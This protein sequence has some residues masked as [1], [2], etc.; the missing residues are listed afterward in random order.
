MSTEQQQQKHQPPDTGPAYYV[1]IGASA[2]GLEALET[3]FAQMPSSTGLAFIVIQHLS[4]DYKSL[5]VEL[6]SKKTDMHVHRAE[7]GMPIEPNCVYLIPPRKTLTMYRGR[8]LLRDQAPTRGLNLPIDV[9]FRSLADDQGERAVAIVLSGTGSDGTRGIR[10]VKD[11]GGLVFVQ[12]PKSARFDGMPRAA[13][14]TGL[15]D[16]VLSPEAMPDQLVRI[17]DHPHE[18]IRANDEKRISEDEG[19]L[20]RIFSL[21]RERVGADFSHYKSSTVLRRIERR[22]MVAQ[23]TDLDD[24]VGFMERRSSEVVKLYKELLIHVTSFFRDREVFEYL[25]SD[26]LPRMLREN[27]KREFRLWV[28]G[29][30]TGEEA[31]TLAILCKETAHNLG[32][33]ADIKLFATDIDRDAIMPA[34]IGSYPESTVADVPG[35]YLAKYFH[36]DESGFR[37]ARTIREMVVFA[38]HNVLS[39]PPFTNLDLISCRNLLI[40]LQ[41]SMQQKALELFNFALR[42]RGI[43]LLGTSETVGDLGEYY[44]CVH[45]KHRVYRS[46][47]RRK[48]PA[49]RS[50]NELPVAVRS[51]PQVQRSQHESSSLSS[52]DAVLERFLNTVVGDYLPLTVIVNESLEI[53]HI[54]GDTK[55]YFRLP[56]GRIVNDISR[57]ATK[58]LSIPLS[59]G[60]RKAFETSSQIRYSGIRLSDDP[61]GTTVTMR[62]KPLDGRKNQELLAAVFL[63][64]S[65]TEANSQKD[66]PVI[67]YNAAEETQQR[68]RDLEHEL[69]FTKENL[70]ATIE[71]L[72]TSNEELQATN[73][74]LLASNEELQSTNEELQSVNEELHTVNAEYQGKLIEY[75]ELTHDLEN[76]LTST[77]I[78]TLFL[79]E[80]MDIRRFTPRIRDVFSILDTD[81][82]RPI[83]DLQHNLESVNVNQVIRT[84]QESSEM[85]EIEVR[86]HAKDWYLLRVLPYHVAPQTVSGVVLTF[87]NINEVIRARS[88]LS[89]T[90][91][92]YRLLFESMQSGYIRGRVLRDENGSPVDVLLTQM[93]DAFESLTGLTKETVT[94]TRLSEVIPERNE[95]VLRWFRRIVWVVDRGRSLRFHGPMTGTGTWLSVFAEPRDDGEFAAFL[96]DISH[97]KAVEQRL[98]WELAVNTCVAE[99]GQKLLSGNR[100]V[101]Q[102]CTEVLDATQKIT[103]SPHGYV[104][105]IDPATRDNICHTF[106]DM[107]GGECRTEGADR[108]ICFSPDES[109]RY[110]ALWGHALNTRRAFY[111]NDPA[112]HKASIGIPDGHISLTCFLS[113]PVIDGDQLVGQIVVANSPQGYEEKHVAAIGR[114]ALTYAMAVR[115]TRLRAE[116]GHHE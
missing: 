17:V 20:G 71:E 94:R 56:S 34:G 4:P 67:A 54:L 24:Y 62:V 25:S 65:M 77:K 38:Q 78:G 33:E 6:L 36:R 113:Y 3:F 1:G 22:M 92:D 39:D 55:G 100:S 116:D 11:A 108:R 59:T 35:D 47:G 81:I 15:S 2:G 93:N 8:L 91:E 110:P 95:A 31:Y 85:M 48:K 61:E 18:E 88:E 63:E 30:S 76:L 112:S 40:Y 103:D 102:L 115:G 12:D 72:E 97:Q 52:D 74:E 114:I 79:D 13:I 99:L 96:E 104:S 45:Q 51:L 87:I 101:K 27:G 46:A 43:L 37:V 32:V 49:E 106:T 41:V 10:S 86:T 7:E 19:G 80:N 90:R 5:M 44:E 16:F 60:I 69:Q 107:F 42:P 73:E 111:T 66:S 14:S 68:I 21:I 28:P 83:T 82:G 89:R 26:V 84:V 58:E 98:S 70:Q 9:F 53:L 23:I 57:M 50:R 105:E 64:R 75:T 109:G 29:C